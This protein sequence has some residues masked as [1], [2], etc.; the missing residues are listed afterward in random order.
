MTEVP[1]FGLELVLFGKTYSLFH[2]TQRTANVVLMDMPELL[3]LPLVHFFKLFRRTVL[4]PRYGVDAQKMHLALGREGY[5]G[6]QGVMAFEIDSKNATRTLC[7]FWDEVGKYVFRF[8]MHVLVTDDD[9]GTDYGTDMDDA[10]AS[11]FY[12]SGDVFGDEIE[13]SMW[14]VPVDIVTKGERDHQTR[15]AQIDWRDE[16]ERRPSFCLM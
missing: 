3:I 11:D 13:S 5:E 9:Y 15:P 2:A 16:F 4:N 10:E 14:K 12:Y 1:P 7:D 6:L 8:E